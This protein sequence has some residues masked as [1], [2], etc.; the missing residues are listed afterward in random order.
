MREV[1]AFEEHWTDKSA[2]KTRDFGD[3]AK[4]FD[5]VIHVLQRDHRSG[6]QAVRRGLAEVS[7][8]VVVGAGERVGDVGVFDQVEALGE[9][10]RVEEG[11]IDPHRI[12]VAQASLRVGRPSGHRMPMG[13]VELADLVPGHAGAPDSPGAG[14]WSSMRAKD[15][16]VDLQIRA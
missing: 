15:L 13:G 3:P 1:V 2:T 4:L 7:D 16:A 11:L 6:K 14:C 5:G 10:G 12:H 9:P 8:P